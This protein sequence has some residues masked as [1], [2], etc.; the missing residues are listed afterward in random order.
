VVV[1]EEAPFVV[2]EELPEFPGG[3]DA[4][5]TWIAA[6]INYPAEALKRKIQGKVYVS[7]TVSAAGKV[8]DA[9]ITKSVSPLLNEEAIRVISSVHDWKPG[10][11]G[12]KAVNIQMLV[13]VEFKLK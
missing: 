7:F 2:V 5:M 6:N 1:K 9:V 3:E 4:M 13:P 11:Q 10:S 12:G 8:N